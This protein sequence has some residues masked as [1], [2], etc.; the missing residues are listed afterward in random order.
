MSYTLLILLASDEAAPG[1]LCQERPENEHSAPVCSAHG[2]SA[3]TSS[4]ISLLLLLNLALG[5]GTRA[6]LN[7]LSLPETGGRRA[8]L[9]EHA[10]RFVLVNCLFN[11]LQG[12]TRMFYDEPTRCWIARWP[13]SGDQRIFSYAC[14]GEKHVLVQILI[15]Q[16]RKDAGGL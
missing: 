7:A 10:Q 3:P 16:G 2:R 6:E 12:P 4:P 9:K 14:A 8:G 13:C 15:A 11:R 5:E 1:L